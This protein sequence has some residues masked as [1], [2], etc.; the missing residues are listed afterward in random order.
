MK[1][2]AFRFSKVNSDEDAD[3]PD[4][5]PDQDPGKPDPALHRSGN[6]IFV[7]LLQDLLIL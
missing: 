1:I 4:S 3:E 2:N 6:K 5:D 7:T